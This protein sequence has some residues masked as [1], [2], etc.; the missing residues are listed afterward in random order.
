MEMMMMLVCCLVMGVVT[1]YMCFANSRLHGKNKWLKYENEQLGKQ[2]EY[3]KSQRLSMVE[4]YGKL[5][6]NWS[7]SQ[8]KAIDRLEEKKDKIKA[9][10]CRDK[11]CPL[12][13]EES[14]MKVISDFNV[15]D[16]VWFVY[17]EQIR[18]GK[19]VLITMQ[20]GIA[21]TMN[22]IKGDAYYTMQI[23]NDD[24]TIWGISNPIKEDKVFATREELIDSLSTTQIG[25]F[26]L[27][28]MLGRLDLFYEM[29]KRIK[30]DDMTWAGIKAECD[31]LLD[32]FR[33]E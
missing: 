17:G 9:E 12:N 33:K 26:E 11:G 30:Q 31:K 20:S 24:D 27:C 13:K 3:S 29:D 6:A 19:V 10:C 32:K 5:Y 16:I 8:T 22:E 25:V 18:R 15:G 2:L 23:L 14:S 7:A 1:L 21:V 4:E 28:K